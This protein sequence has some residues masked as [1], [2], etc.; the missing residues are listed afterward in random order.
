MEM[1]PRKREGQDLKNSWPNIRARELQG[2]EE[3][4]Q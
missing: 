4:S 3:I 2:S 1:L